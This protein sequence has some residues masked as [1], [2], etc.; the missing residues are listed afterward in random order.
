MKIIEIANHKDLVLYTAQLKVEKSNKALELTNNFYDFAEFLNPDSAEQEPLNHLKSNRE[1]KLDLVEMVLNIGVNY[2]IFK[3]FG[4]NKNFLSFI[5]KELMKIVYTSL[6][7]SNLSKTIF[8]IINLIKP[9]SEK[10]L[11]QSETA[12]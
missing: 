3:T 2:F 9:K 5:A 4:K 6:L 11:E 1:A 12:N 8:E 10:E 7:K